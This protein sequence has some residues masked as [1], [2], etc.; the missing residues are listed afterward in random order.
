MERTAP[1][2]EVSL[3]PSPV[4]DKCTVLAETSFPQTLPRFHV[5]VTLGLGCRA[6]SLGAAGKSEI[7]PLGE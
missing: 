7:Q 6:M 1:N 2:G 5:A 3:T 4:S